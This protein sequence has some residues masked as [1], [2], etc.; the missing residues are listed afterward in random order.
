M[1]L[2]VWTYEGPPHVG[3]MRVA[4]AMRD[5]HFV[6]HA[7]FFTLAAHEFTFVQAEFPA[8]RLPNNQQYNEDP[9]PDNQR[10]GGE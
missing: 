9:G 10:V 5:I 6:L 3:A 8:A 7:P 1:K 2:A 4:T